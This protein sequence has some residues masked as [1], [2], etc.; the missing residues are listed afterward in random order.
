MTEIVLYLKNGLWCYQVE[1]G[2]MSCPPHIFSREEARRWF[3][4]EYSVSFGSANGGFRRERQ[5]KVAETPVIKVKPVKAPK[6]PKLKAKEGAGRKSFTVAQYDKNGV[7]MKLWPKVSVA[8]AEME[9]SRSVIHKCCSGQYAT[10]A[11]YIW[12]WAP[13]G[14]YKQQIQGVGTEGRKRR[15]I[16]KDLAG[17]EI[18]RYDSIYAAAKAEGVSTRT[19]RYH[20]LESKKPLHMKVWE[21]A[22]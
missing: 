17:E 14:K 19:L 8:A 9:C 20:I 6:G 18:A 10:A 21:F 1:G 11:G 15:V 22:G 3:G 12:R 13:S 4:P 5:P 2:E 16:A 7:F